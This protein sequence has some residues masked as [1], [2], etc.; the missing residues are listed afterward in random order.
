MNPSTGQS[1]KRVWPTKLSST[2]IWLWKFLSKICPSNLS[3]QTKKVLNLNLK[4]KWKRCGLYF[5][6]FMTLL[7]PLEAIWSKRCGP[8]QR[9]SLRISMASK[10]ARQ[11][12]LCWI[13]ENGWVCCMSALAPTSIWKQEGTFRSTLWKGNTW[14]ARSTDTCLLGSWKGLTKDCCLGTLIASRSS[15]RIRTLFTNFIKGTFRMKVSIWS[16]ICH[17]CSTPWW[18]TFTTRK[19]LWWSWEFLASNS[20]PKIHT[21]MDTSAPINSD[22]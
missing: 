16:Q 3:K 6:T 13:S 8:G 17:N 5:L 9:C 22:K 1:S 10:M 12:I 15:Q 21:K 14:R 4:R 20:L 19:C 7:N 2:G 11:C 18:I